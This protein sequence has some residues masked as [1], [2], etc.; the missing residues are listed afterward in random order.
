MVQSTQDRSST[1]SP[2][3]NQGNSIQVT[4]IVPDQVSSILL[5]DGWHKV[6]N[7]RFTHFALAEGMSPP[8]PNKLY[9]AI[10]YRDGTT[11][12]NVITPLSQVLSF[13]ASDTY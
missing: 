7:C 9:A 10:Q 2:S 6:E 13:E 3:S 12:K 1:Q 11:G 5:A 8:Q 4:S